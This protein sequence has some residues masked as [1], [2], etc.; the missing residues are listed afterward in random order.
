MRMKRHPNDNRVQSETPG[1]QPRNYSSLAREAYPHGQHVG[2]SP[3]TGHPEPHHQE[4]D[5]HAAPMGGRWTG[6]GVRPLNAAPPSIPPGASIPGRPEAGRIPLAQRGNL[7]AVGVA[8]GAGL[9]GR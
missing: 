1:S 2:S 4:Y 7:G 5:G 9:F 6:S 3:A 8:S